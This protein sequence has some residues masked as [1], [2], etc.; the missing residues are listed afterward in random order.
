MFDSEEVGEVQRVV[1]PGLD[2]R[3]RLRVLLA[4]Q[5]SLRG[6]L[7]RYAGCGS[8]KRPNMSLM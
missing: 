2:A 8:R 7:C 4:G 3:L 6:G 5:D 1:N